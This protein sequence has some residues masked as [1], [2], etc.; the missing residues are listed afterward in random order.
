MANISQEVRQRIVDIA[1]DKSFTVQLKSTGA[2]IYDKNL[3]FQSPFFESAVFI[4]KV[5]GITK[6][7]GD[8]SYLKVAVHSDEF[9]AELIN[10][11]LGIEE[12]INRVSKVNQHHHSSYREG[13]FKDDGSGREPYA[14]CY[15]VH[16][17]SALAALFAGL[18][19][20][21]S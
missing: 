1:K 13:D 12:C 17:L 5:T 2:D 3:M 6:A 15:R 8:F 18:T 9:K 21:K 19:G 7:S 20:R 10:P 16:N 14:K 11:A 4:D